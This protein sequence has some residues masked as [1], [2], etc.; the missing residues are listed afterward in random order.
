MYISKEA[1]FC[2]QPLI[3]ESSFTDYTDVKSPAKHH[4]VNKKHS[5][6]A[7]HTIILIIY[8]NVDQ[9]HVFYAWSNEINK[10]GQPII[11]MP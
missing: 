5:G 4:I 3:G 2:S 9:R 11:I 7:T 6:A 8:H 10:I 1:L